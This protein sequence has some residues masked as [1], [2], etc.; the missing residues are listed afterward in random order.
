MDDIDTK[1]RLYLHEHNNELRFVPL[2]ACENCTYGHMDEEF[3]KIIVELREL[4]P[5]ITVD[6]DLPLANTRGDMLRETHP[7]LREPVFMHIAH[8]KSTDED[9]NEHLTKA[10]D[11]LVLEIENL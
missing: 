7:N 5:S 3:E 9:F 8:S 1:L 10:K 2:V 4:Y 6:K 11:V